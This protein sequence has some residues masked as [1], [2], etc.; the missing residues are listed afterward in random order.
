[1]EGTLLRNGFQ[2]TRKEVVVVYFEVLS[3]YLLWW[4]EQITKHR[5]Y[6]IKLRL[7]IRTQNLQNKK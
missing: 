7:K 6:N 4:T 5:S 1:M 3:R 2:T